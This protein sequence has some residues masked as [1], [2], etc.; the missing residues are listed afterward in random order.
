M[1]LG[2]G[3]VGVLQGVGQG[4]GLSLRTCIFEAFLTGTLLI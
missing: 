1:E 2:F 4:Y 3:G